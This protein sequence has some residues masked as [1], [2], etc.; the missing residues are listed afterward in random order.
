MAIFGNKKAPAKKKTPAKKAVKAAAPV[1]KGDVNASAILM[2]PRITEKSAQLTASRVY[3]FD[4]SPRANK[5]DV[6]RAIQSVY[7]VTPEKV[8]V[9]NTPGKRVR[10]RTRRG[11]GTASALKKAYV[12]LKEGDRIEFSS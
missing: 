1:K 12:Y 10:L 8:R 7:N 9:V 3:T 4:I 11:Q 6:A 2:R 5:T